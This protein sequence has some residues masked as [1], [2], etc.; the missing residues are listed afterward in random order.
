MS[1]G[2][3]NDGPMLP[4][5][6]PV[7]PRD[8][9]IVLIGLAVAL[10]PAG[11]LA[12]AKFAPAQQVSEGYGGERVPTLGEVA[13]GVAFIRWTQGFLLSSPRFFCAHQLLAHCGDD[14]VLAL[15]ARLELLDLPVGSITSP[16]TSGALE[17]GRRV[18]EERLLP[19]VE[20]RGVNLMLVAALGDGLPFYEVE[21]ESPDFFLT[22]KLSARASRLVVVD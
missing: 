7:I 6:E 13:N 5:F 18:F 8:L 9:S 2:E 10:P 16:G 14:L 20:E 17:R 3:V 21:L 22:G 11:E 4:G 1:P 12:G 19:A 15:E